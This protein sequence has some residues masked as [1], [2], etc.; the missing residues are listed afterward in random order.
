M[1]LIVTA[2][3]AVAMTYNI[4]RLHWYT[5]K[6]ALFSTLTFWIAVSGSVILIFAYPLSGY[7]IHTAGGEFS[8][9]LYPVWM[10]ILFWYGFILNATLFNG[11]ILLDLIN[12]LLTKILRFKRT[13]LQTVLGLLA[14]FLM[15]GVLLFTSVK[16]GMDTY[17]VQTERIEHTVTGETISDSK[18]LRVAHISEIHA[19]RFTSRE[20]IARYMNHVEAANPDI[21][22][23]TGD[24]I[25]DG[26]DFVDGAAE[27]LMSVDAPLG[28]W[29]VMGD[30]DYWAGPDDVT[31]ILE[32]R[33][34]N[35]LRDE[36]AWI[37]HNGTLLRLT[38][39]TEVYSTSVDRV[40]FR[41][42]LAERRNETYRILFSHQATDDLLD[43]AQESGVDLFLAGHTHGGQIRVPFFYR[44]VTAAQ[45]ETNFVRGF[46][47]LD[48]MLLSINSG[49]G[50][51][52]APLRFNAPA[53]VSVIELK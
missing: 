11:L 24:L 43:E 14:I 12:L 19:D 36:N 1:T 30:H 48:D 40:V 20:T 18:P 22:L 51:T 52:L 35:V 44:M 38:G 47:D 45:L 5:K 28:T 53:E 17:R 27:E 15:A 31:E 50:Y 41:E 23:V 6:T 49:L 26:L 39:I 33:G 10:I 9:D 25:S 21:M 37:D 42:L 32:S 8:R 2:L 4:I 34:I 16:T 29:F 3:T 7:G 46:Y 13:Q